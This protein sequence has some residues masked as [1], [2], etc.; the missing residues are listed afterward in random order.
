MRYA[1]ATFETSKPIHDPQTMRI[2]GSQKANHTKVFREDA[3][4]TEVLKW[5]QNEQA[6]Q[7]VIAFENRDSE[8]LNEPPKITPVQ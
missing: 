3:P 8:L 6:I 5:L 1:V 7:V 2:L 4:L